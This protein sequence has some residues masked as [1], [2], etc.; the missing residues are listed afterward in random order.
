MAPLYGGRRYQNRIGIPNSTTPLHVQ[1]VKDMLVEIDQLY[2]QEHVQPA[3]KL[4]AEHSHPVDEPDLDV[5]I[6]AAACENLP[7]EEVECLRRQHKA[8]LQAEMDKLAEEFIKKNVVKLHRR[9]T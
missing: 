8:Q 2:A 7:D 3:A 6:G 5:D 4:I 9:M 1:S